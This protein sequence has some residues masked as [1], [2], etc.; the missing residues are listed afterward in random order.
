MMSGCAGVLRELLVK[1]TLNVDEA[2]FVLAKLASENIYY[3]AEENKI[4]GI[5]ET[6]RTI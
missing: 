6:T 5:Y 1:N 3:F 4:L 2:S